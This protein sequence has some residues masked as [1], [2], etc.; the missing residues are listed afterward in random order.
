MIT[1]CQRTAL[2]YFMKGLVLRMDRD[3]QETLIDCLVDINMTL[4]QELKGLKNILNQQL[5]N[6]E[7]T[8]E[9][10]SMHKIA[11]ILENW[12]RRT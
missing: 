6:L 4:R 2:S 1:H 9:N 5:M 11:K 7:P 3:I 8:L 12:E 10:S